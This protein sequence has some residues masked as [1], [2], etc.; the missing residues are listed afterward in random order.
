MMTVEFVRAVVYMAIHIV[1]F[2]QCNLCP[3]TYC[4]LCLLNFVDLDVQFA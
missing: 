1:E 2:H 4:H 3:L